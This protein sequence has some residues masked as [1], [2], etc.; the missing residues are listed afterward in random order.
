MGRIL[1]W[2]I[3]RVDYLVVFFVLF[4][5]GTAQHA[6][7]YYSDT[8]WHLR[9]GE[10]IWQHGPPFYDM[11]SYTMAGQPFVDHQWLGEALFY[12]AYWV[13]G[14]LGVPLLGTLLSMAT[15]GILWAAIRKVNARQRITQWILIP[16]ICVYLFGFQY[17]LRPAIFGEVLLAAVIAILM[18]VYHGIWPTRRLYWL[19]ALFVLWAN[20]HLTWTVGLL[21]V[22]ACG[23]GVVWE[24]KGQRWVAV[25]RWGSVLA[26]C[27]GGL[28]LT[29]YTWQIPVMPIRGFLVGTGN[30]F[31]YI[32]EW[33]SPSFPPGN[34]GSWLVIA[35]LLLPWVAFILGDRRPRITE[36]LLVL[37]AEV[38]AFMATRFLL[39]Y[40]LIFPLVIAPQIESVW[41]RFTRAYPPQSYKSPLNLSS[42]VLLLEVLT[43][44][45]LPL[46]WSAVMVQKAGN[47]D[48]HAGLHDGTM[49]A[50]AG[51]YIQENP[52]VL[53]GELLAPY[54]WGGFL[55]FWVRVPVYIDGRTDFYQGAFLERY[56]DFA[57]LRQ[58]WDP[59]EK[60]LVDRWN[61][62]TILWYQPSPL[63]EVLRLDP[64][65]QL[66]WEDDTA[67][68]FGRRNL[69]GS[70][71][72]SPPG[73]WP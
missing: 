13:F 29:P 27:V 28:F 3:P 5:T 14:P 34:V 41:S 32:A 20:L 31:R 46:G 70:T 19:P 62:G 40:G 47:W 35:T 45:L 25:K 59:E 24:S 37:I 65:W 23:V 64:D 57:Y 33:Q 10:Y 49:P 72:T 26:L 60:E 55:T 58:P 17:Y 68:I 4:V 36:V 67:V 66:L 22:G 12:G 54:E 73:D 11:L 21:I 7:A 6:G 38:P 53:R 1:T 8:W 69:L 16:I 61:V 50:D 51:R 30:L 71:A 9:L 52:A 18:L 63:A 42:V 44:V 43:I 2:L 48:W 15:A 39:S 56:I